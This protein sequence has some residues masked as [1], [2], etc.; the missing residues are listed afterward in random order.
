VSWSVLG[1]R[2]ILLSQ[3]YSHR[4]A[5]LALADA[6]ALFRRCLPLITDQAYGAG[7]LVST[8]ACHRMRLAPSRKHNTDP[9]ATPPL[10]AQA[11][12]PTR[13]SSARLASSASRPRSTSAR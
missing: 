11:R 2:P 6:A 10:R 9:H 5:P 1:R 8:R 12:R 4:A 13:W 3:L 7:E